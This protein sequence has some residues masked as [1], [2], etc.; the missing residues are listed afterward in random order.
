MS[1]PQI[2]QNIA[3]VAYGVLASSEEPWLSAIEVETI[4]KAE[5]REKVGIEWPWS[6]RPL[7]YALR[8][9][10]RNGL[11]QERLV[12]YRGTHRST[13]YRREYCLTERV[14]SPV[15]LLGQLSAAFAVPEH[16]RRRICRMGI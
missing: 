14:A 7:A 3:V 15:S 1:R 9:L 10:A 12:P 4:A 13:E 5:L 6:Y 8:K 16:A 2:Q 11:V